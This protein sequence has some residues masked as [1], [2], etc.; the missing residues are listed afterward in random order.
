[1]RFS[2]HHAKRAAHHLKHST[3]VLLCV[4]CIEYVADKAV[5][6][7]KLFFIHVIGSVFP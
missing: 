7:I 6:V 1:M 5:F 3:R 4:A 2:K